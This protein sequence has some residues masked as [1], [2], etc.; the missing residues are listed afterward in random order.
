MHRAAAAAVGGEDEEE[1]LG[2]K[3]QSVVAPPRFVVALSSKARAADAAPS[4]FSVDDMIS[5]LRDG[6]F[7]VDTELVPPN[8][9]VTCADDLLA[10]HAAFLG[11]PTSLWKPD[12][13]PCESVFL[14]G[15]AILELP[16]PVTWKDEPPTLLSVMEEAGLIEGFFPLHDPELLQSITTDPD[17]VHSYFGPRIALYF[18]YMQHY[19]RWL[20][21]PAAA[22]MA[23]HLFH[24]FMRLDVDDSPIMMLFSFLMCIWGACFVVSWKRQ[25]ARLG[26]R[27]KT[28]R[29]PSAA[30]M[31]HGRR[32]LPSFRG[33]WRLS[34]ISGKPERYF[35]RTKRFPRYLLS[36]CISL[37]VLAVAVAFMLAS[38]NLQGYVRGK[39][40]SRF[41]LVPHLARL[42]KKGAPFHPDAAL[43]FG[44][45]PPS[46]LVVAMHSV[47]INILNT[48]YSAVARKLTLFENHRT[49]RDFAN[50]LIMKRFIFEFLDCYSSLFFLAFVD[51]SI[52]S[53]RK[54]LMSLF[55]VDTVRRV[56]MESVLPLLSQIVLEGRAVK[57]RRVSK[58]G[59]AFDMSIGAQVS[60]MDEYHQ[61]EDFLEMTIQWGYVT[62]FAGA[63]P[64][65]ATFANVA[66]WLEVRSDLFGLL[67]L[68]RRP[69][70][71][72]SK[73]IGC[74][75][76][77]L[78]LMCLLAT[79]T[80]CALIFLASDQ[81]A[82]LGLMTDIYDDST[83][84]MSDNGAPIKKGMAGWVV[85]M[86]F[87]WEHLI[88]FLILC[89]WKLVPAIPEDVQASLTKDSFLL[90][91]G[92]EI[93]SPLPQGKRPSYWVKMKET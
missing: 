5:A 54:E 41:F 85:G 44:I 88:A 35:P 65:A 61:F 82:A 87:L 18:G 91:G 80:N 53:L 69:L 7:D 83:R 34:L 13:L 14:L 48:L 52:A 2:R 49:A 45:I 64:L 56:C 31:I 32:E 23:V 84:K 59:K 6:G 36:I 92:A 42:A 27:W 74:W 39:G 51:C 43:W 8:L 24:R 28:V 93:V 21:A 81:A 19:R 86:S 50:S 68:H 90:M 15:D 25:A 46:L 60:S 22:G 3:K 12:R 9:I 75:Q 40:V 38:M 89:I 1:V 70:P 78:E 67:C 63:F 11:L 57:R 77:I 4:W 73:D 71:V 62:L 33:E 37:P 79:L 76:D 10:R 47:V 17:S 66:D 58:V 29:P 72:R 20:L 16:K 55:V 26:Y 30:D